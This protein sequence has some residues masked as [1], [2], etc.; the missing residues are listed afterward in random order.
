[1]FDDYVCMNVHMY[2]DCVC[3]CVDI[4]TR[5]GRGIGSRACAIIDRMFQR[6]VTQVQFSTRTQKI[7]V[8]KKILKNIKKNN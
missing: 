5:S 7:L 1:M 2:D 8:K 6:A 3:V 4:I